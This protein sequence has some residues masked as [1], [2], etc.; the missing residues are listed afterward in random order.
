LLP[1]VA[2]DAVHR[3]LEPQVFASGQK[4]IERGLLQRGTDRFSHLRPLLDDVEAGNA[5]CSGSGR[6]QRGQHVH[7]RRLPRTVRT[8]EAVDLAGLDAQVDAVDGARSLLELA[9]EAVRLDA[10][11][12][13]RTHPRQAI[14]RAARLSSGLELATKNS[15]DR[16]E[17]D[18]RLVEIWLTRRQAL[19]PETG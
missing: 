11:V 1:L 17:R 14:D 2:G 3:R 12:E 18:A 13:R 5:R 16:G 4:R 9:D 7:G 10:V 8:E 19:Q 15:S 6:Q